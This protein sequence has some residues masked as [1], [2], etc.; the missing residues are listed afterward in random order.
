LKHVEQQRTIAARGEPVGHRA[1]SYVARL[2]QQHHPRMGLQFDRL[3]NSIAIEIGILTRQ[4]DRV[5][6]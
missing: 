4:I 2:E 1:N 6:L 5:R 3:T